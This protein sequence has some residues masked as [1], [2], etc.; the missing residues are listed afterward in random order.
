M[1]LG[2]QMMAHIKS[3]GG[4][5]KH[6]WSQTVVPNATH[7][8]HSFKRCQAAGK[9]PRSQTVAK[10]SVPTQ[11]VFPNTRGCP[12]HSWCQTMVQTVSQTVVP[13]AR[14]LAR[15]PRLMT[16]CWSSDGHQTVIRRFVFEAY[17]LAAA[18]M[19]TQLERK[20]GD[21]SRYTEQRKR[22]WS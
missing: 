11:T 2:S 12:K 15:A 7:G 5:P 14:S 8:P 18:D 19:R 9:H 21:T 22:L 1:F 13:Q 20:D 17:T 3:L 6:S 4:G 16:V 10:R